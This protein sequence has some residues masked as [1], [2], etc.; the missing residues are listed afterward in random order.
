MD[1]IIHPI[2]Q[3]ETLRPR[4]V[5][6]WPATMPLAELGSNPG[7]S[8]QPGSTLVAFAARSDIHT[9]APGGAAGL[10]PQA[11]ALERTALEGGRGL[12]QALEGSVHLA[13]WKHT[14]FPGSIPHRPG[15]L[16]L[17]SASLPSWTVCMRTCYVDGCVRCQCHT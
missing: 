3:M 14:G 4:G 10:P 6:Y 12:G 1:T 9:D 13:L 11:P 17:F 16:A 15:L 2:L 7:L 8:S 5:N